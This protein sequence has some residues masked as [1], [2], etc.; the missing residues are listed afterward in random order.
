MDANPL[1][2]MIMVSVLLRYPNYIITKMKIEIKTENGKMKKIFARCSFIYYNKNVRIQER[3]Y[4]SKQ[5]LNPEKK[6]GIKYGNQ[7]S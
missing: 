2:L 6:R 3:N 4:F 7:K 1:Y 5:R